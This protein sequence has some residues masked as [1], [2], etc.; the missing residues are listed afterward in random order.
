MTQDE[1]LEKLSEIVAD[2]LDLDDLNLD[3]TTTAKEVAGW[4]SVAHIQIMIAV[5][6]AFGIR[7]KTGELAAVENIGKLADRIASRLVG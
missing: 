3:V 1:I 5:E 6:Q 2:V 4:D 7:F